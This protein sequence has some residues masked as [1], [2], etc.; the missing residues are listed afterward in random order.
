[1]STHV[2]PIQFTP[3]GLVVPQASDVLAGRQQDI[4]DAFGGGVN[5][6][7]KT[8][9]GQLATSDSAIINDNNGTFALFVNQVDPD[10]ADGAMQDALGRIYF[11]E[12]NP[13]LPTSVQVFCSGDFGVN[14]PLGMRVQDTSGNQY[15]C[16]QAGTIPVGGNIT[17]TFEC[18]VLGPTP[19]PSNTVTTIVGPAPNG[20]DS[21]N[22]PSAGAVGA[23]VESRA[24]FEFRRQQSV[25]LNAHGSIVSI[26]A[27]VFDVSN[28]IDVYAIENFTNI[29]VNVGA[30][31]FPLVA[32]SIYIGVVGGADA[33]IGQAIFSKKNDGSNMNGNTDVIITDASYDPPQPQYPYT[34]NRPDNTAFV[35]AV[36]IQSSPSL[37]AN[38]VQLT[39]AAVVKAFNG[40]DGSKRVRMGSTVLAGKF[41]AP[42]SAVAPS[43]N[44]ISV[45]LNVSPGSPTLTN[46]TLGIDQFPTLQP[47]DVAVSLV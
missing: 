32:H 10:T 4:D 7:L 42:I 29:T 9:Q 39:Q 40:T 16:V 3:T 30:T 36:Q 46:F 2:P 8:P 14:I 24:E 41:Y 27:A 17:L 47:T 6:A 28:V 11:M 15:V 34:F 25:A 37:P 22:N 23:D 21:V 44:V 1:M 26:G 33:D 38:I 12:R 18:V 5:P 43:V 20:L 31:N 45:L 13:G 19:C 35:F